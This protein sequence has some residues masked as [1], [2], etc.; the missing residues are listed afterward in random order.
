VHLLSYQRPFQ[1]GA[2]H[3]R[4]GDPFVKPYFPGMGDVSI[5]PSYPGMG[6]PTGA[7]AQAIRPL[8]GFG[9]EWRQDGV[10]LTLTIDGAPIRVFVPL[11]TI[12]AALH[13]EMAAVGCPLQGGMG[14]PMSVGSIFGSIAH[15]VSSAASSVVHA[16]AP[17]VAKAATAVVH[18]AASAGKTIVQSKIIRYGLDAAAVAVPALAPAAVALETAH[19]ALEHVNQGI[20]AAKAI[21][22]GVVTAAN[23]AKAT[24]G[25]NTQKAMATVVSKAQA[26]NPA[27][28]SMVGA[29]QQ[30]ALTRAAAASPNPHAFLAQVVRASPQIANV[31]QNALLQVAQVAQQ[32]RATALRPYRVSRRA[33]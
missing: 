7:I 4:L 2:H 33:A 11:Q 25:L 26:G 14:E 1:R 9:W 15:A 29:L 32:A 28:Q 3:K 21:K 5:R 27:A 12:W 13:H 30:L 20:A 23:V 24:L 6:D 31:H 17:A 18:T 22:S 16:V 10:I 19:Q 8:T